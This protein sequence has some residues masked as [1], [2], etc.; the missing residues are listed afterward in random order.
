MRATFRA[1]DGLTEFLPLLSFMIS[2]F[3]QSYETVYCFNVINP[4]HSLSGV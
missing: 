1:K 2:L 4:I 3:T